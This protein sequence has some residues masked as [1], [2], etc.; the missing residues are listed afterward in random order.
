M[1]PLAPSSTFDERFKAL[2]HTN[3]EAEANEGQ[4]SSRNNE[5][6]D[7]HTL[8]REWRAPP[9]TRV[10]IPIRI[11][12]KVYFATERTSLSWLNFLIY[13]GSILS[14]HTIGADLSAPRYSHS[15]H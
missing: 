14:L 6:E 11:E 8:T 3:E 12:P 4:V 2:K 1:D 5:T 9:D 13:I 15:P 10:A 7:D